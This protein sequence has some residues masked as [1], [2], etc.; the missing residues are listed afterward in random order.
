MY[1]NANVFSV[2]VIALGLLFLFHYLLMRDVVFHGSFRQAVIFGVL[3]LPTVF[4]G[5]WTVLLWEGRKIEWK[6]IAVLVVLSFLLMSS[7]SYIS[8][9]MMMLAVVAIVTLGFVKLLGTERIRKFIFGAMYGMFPAVLLE[10][11]ACFFSASN[12]VYGNLLLGVIGSSVSNIFAGFFLFLIVLCLPMYTILFPVYVLD[13]FAK[14]RRYRMFSIVFVITFPILVFVSSSFGRDII[15][16]QKDPCYEVVEGKSPTYLVKNDR[17]CVQYYES[18]LGAS[19]F[20]TL[21][22]A[23]VNTF[24]EIGYQYAK[25]KDHVYRGVEIDNSFDPKSFHDIGAGYIAD[26]QQVAYFTEKI[27]SADSTSFVVLG[28]GNYY[29]KDAYQVYYHGDVLQGADARTFQVLGREEYAKDAEQVYYADRVI[30]GADSSSF[31]RVD[32]R[33]SHDSHHVF[34]NGEMMKNLDFQSYER[35]GTTDYFRDT[36][37]LYYCEEEVE[38]VNVR[39]FRALPASHSYSDGSLSVWDG[40]GTDGK[41]V[42]CDGKNRSDDPREFFGDRF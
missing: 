29:A 41:V 40:C 39:K 19:F 23:D 35:I 21:E 3:W 4:V 16:S 12:D 36:D 1:I 31:V 15:L 22:G 7:Y 10:T 6:D 14:E 33:I 42:V 24:R 28:N 37:S 32:L 26:D 25:D 30:E 11:L 17:V 27:P 38:G 13:F 20:K 2:R 5:S 34:C 18:A 9:A 8:V